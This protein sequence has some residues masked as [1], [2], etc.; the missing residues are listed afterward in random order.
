MHRHLFEEAIDWYDPHGA[1]SISC[2][3]RREIPIK[4]HP[5]AVEIPSDVELQVRPRGCD[6]EEKAVQEERE[7][8]ALEVLYVLAEQI[9]ESPAEPGSQIPLDQVDVSAKTMLAGVDVQPFFQQALS[10]QDLVGQLKGAEPA[11]SVDQGFPSAPFAA[12]DLL[13]MVSA[14]G[15]SSSPGVGAP[16]D[17]RQLGLDTSTLS[18]LSTL[19][20]ATTP[21]AGSDDIGN[22]FGFGGMPDEEQGGFRGRGRDDAPG[23]GRRGKGRGGGMDGYRNKRKE[24]CSFYQQGRRASIVRH[25]GQEMLNRKS[26]PTLV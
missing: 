14:T 19:L 4:G 6:S 2:Y 26:P 18:Q 22:G 25:K 9:P 24:P 16:F 13:A 1:H 3:I 8:S 21:A 5:P 20:T 23:R 15:A 12:N 11:A 10:V 17:L 7:K